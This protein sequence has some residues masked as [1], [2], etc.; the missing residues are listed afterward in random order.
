M[1]WSGITGDKG[2]FLDYNFYRIPGGDVAS[3][4]WVRLVYE[5]K[6]VGLRLS[7]NKRGKM[8]GMHIDPS[9][10]FGGPLEVEATIIDSKLVF[11]DGFKYGYPDAYVIQKEG[12]W[13]LKTS[14]AELL[15]KK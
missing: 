7:F 10:S 11:I 12:R 3:S 1:S 9:F 14:S 6:E 13:Y 8:M 4:Y 5:R 15:L 2:K